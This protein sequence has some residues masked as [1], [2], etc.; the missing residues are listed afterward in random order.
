MNSDSFDKNLNLILM[1]VLGICL[2][3]LVCLNKGEGVEMMK[4]TTW[5]RW[6]TSLAIGIATIILLVVIFICIFVNGYGVIKSEKNQYYVLTEKNKHHRSLLKKQKNILVYDDIHYIFPHQFSGFYNL[7]KIEFFGE[8]QIH[9]AAFFGCTNLNEVVFHNNI[10]SI[11][12]N[13]FSGCKILEAITIPKSVTSIGE[14]A[15]A[16]CT[17]LKDITMPVSIA[18]TYGSKPIKITL[19]GTG[20]I[21]NDLFKDNDSIIEIV[22]SD[23]ITV[24]GNNAFKDCTSLA[25][26]TIPKSVTSIGDD[27][28]AGCNKLLTINYTGTKEDWGNSFDKDTANWKK[29]ITS[30]CFIHIDGK[31]YKLENDGK[32]SEPIAE[33]CN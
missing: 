30:K 20:E 18:D 9:E 19:T 24:I 12:K 1:T 22:I 16:G 4:T 23:G 25:T 14:N 15:F 6:G 17:S 32:L 11:G 8:I 29:D 26:I 10:T 13:A 7:E 28:F 27:A 3:A 33:S 21:K 31:K 2:C 5:I